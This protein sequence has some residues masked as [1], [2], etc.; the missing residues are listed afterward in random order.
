M[1]SRP[2]RRDGGGD[3]AQVVGGLVNVRL[4]HHHFAAGLVVDALRRGF[5]RIFAARPD[6]HARAL[7]HEAMRNRIADAAAAAA[8]DRRLALQLQIHCHFPAVAHPVGTPPA[9]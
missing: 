4:S 6:Q 5:E 8:D 3:D 1:S 7:L 9:S 2:E